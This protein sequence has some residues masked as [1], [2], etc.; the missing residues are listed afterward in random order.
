MITMFHLN[1][2]ALDFGQW[3][4]HCKA[5][6]FV[7][8]KFQAFRL[9]LIFYLGLWVQLIIGTKK[10]QERRKLFGNPERRRGEDQ[11]QGLPEFTMASTHVRA[12]PRL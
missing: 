2:P 7:K 5:L 12:H 9:N 4:T 3:E 6:R 10:S 1:T 11:I 8:N